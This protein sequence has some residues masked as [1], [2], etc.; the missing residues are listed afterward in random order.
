M[1]KRMEIDMRTLAQA[2]GSETSTPLHSFD[3]NG[4]ETA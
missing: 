4:G 1:R 2:L 3:L